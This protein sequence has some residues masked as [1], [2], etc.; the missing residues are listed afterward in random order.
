MRYVF[1]SKILELIV[2]ILY[3]IMKKRNAMPLYAARLV[4]SV[5]FIINIFSLYLLPEVL[6]NRIY[7]SDLPVGGWGISICLVVI[8]YAICYLLTRK[9]ANPDRVILNN[10]LKKRGAIFTY[11]F[12][13]STMIFFIII[14]FLDISIQ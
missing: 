9:I 6:Q 3:K 5:L 1:R 11:S 7:T 13:F 8:S 12:I 2:M 4:I 10:K 14:F